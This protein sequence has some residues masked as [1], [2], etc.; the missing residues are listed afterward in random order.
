MA[1]QF[2]QRGDLLAAVAADLEGLFAQPAEESAPVAPENIA[3]APTPA[4]ARA[5]RDERAVVATRASGNRKWWKAIVAGAL[6]VGALATVL[7]VL[8]LS[9]SGDD[10]GP[11]TVVVPGTQPWTDTG[12]VLHADDSVTVS[13][14]GS[15]E[16]AAG[17]ATTAV[18]PE[19]SSDPGLDVFNVIDGHHAALIGRIGDGDPF[20]VG[21]NSAFVV[22]AP[23]GLLYLGINDKDVAN[24]SGHYTATVTVTRSGD[25][26]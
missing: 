2:L 22:H 6:V 11:A 5:R 20:A 3:P 7:V 23:G 10:A 4:R 24:N 17:N 26:S 21:A 15:V 12:N 19:G 8:L 14:E 1:E 18:G 13:A 25:A 9:G 16:P